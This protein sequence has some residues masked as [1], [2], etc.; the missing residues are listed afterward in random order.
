MKTRSYVSVF[1]VFLVLGF[2]VSGGIGSGA[3]ADPI[4]LRCA[5]Y[6]TH[7]EGILGKGLDLLQVELDK[8]TKGQVKIKT[9]F[10]ETLCK[11]MEIPRAVK[12]GMTDIGPVV[13]VYHPELFP[14]SFGAS[15]STMVTGG[16]ELGDWIEGYRKFYNET[17]EERECFTKNNQKILAWWEYDKMAIIS[18][19]PI[20]SLEDMK[21]VKIRNSGEYLPRMFR[22][23]GFL[24]ISVPAT[25]AYDAVSRGMVDAIH[26][27]PDTAL[28][29]RWYEYCKYYTEAPIYGTTLVFFLSINLDVWNK[30][31]ADI[32]KA[33]VE[34]GEA[35]T[36]AMPGISLQVRKDFDK[37]F[38]AAGGQYLMLPEADQQKWKSM[39]AED[40]MEYYITKMEKKGIPK[41]RELVY[42]FAATMNYKWK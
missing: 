3:F 34:S 6:G 15:Q 33:L 12:S 2:I 31:P 41:V 20:R 39:I 21:N 38:R 13:A 9:Y 37:T 14:Y 18:K 27:S 25:E 28:K 11:M 42:R 36:Q 19:K 1:V 35:M 23:V 16:F 24:P 10:G 29:Y 32:Q 22:A 7:D 17:P 26:A 5:A 4:E 8:R 40:S 30:L